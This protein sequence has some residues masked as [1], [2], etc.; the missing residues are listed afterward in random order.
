[1]DAPARR[2]VCREHDPV[3]LRDDAGEAREEVGEGAL[4]GDG[5]EADR[6]RDV[7]QHVVAGEHQVGVVV[8]EHDVARGVPGCRDDAQGATTRVEALGVGEPRVGWLVVVAVDA[9]G[10]GRPDQVEHGVG[11]GVGERLQL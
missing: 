4:G 6:G 10:L 8:D 3:G 5:L 9:L 11:P 7:R 1:M 2:A